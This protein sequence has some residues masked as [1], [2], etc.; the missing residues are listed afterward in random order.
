MV[1]TLNIILSIGLSFPL[2]AAGVIIAAPLARCC[3]NVWYIPLVIHRDG[4]KK[5]VIRFYKK[6]ILRTLFLTILTTIIYLFSRTII[7]KNGVTII[8]FI[9]MAI[10]TAI[11]TNLIIG[12]VFH[13][14]D[15]FKYFINLFKERIKI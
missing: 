3:I 2:G 4:F 5:S 10:I 9:V 6:V 11:V 12:L 14:T 7:F 8:S 13:S 1:A 15:E